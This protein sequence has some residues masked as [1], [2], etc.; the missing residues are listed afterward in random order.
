MVEKK[1]ERVAGLLLSLSLSLSFALTPS[2]RRRPFKKNCSEGMYVWLVTSTLPTQVASATSTTTKTT[3]AEEHTLAA[4][5][6]LLMKAPPPPPSL[7]FF[8]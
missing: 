2:L 5:D 4:V 3:P 6:C 7:P 8:R 1:S